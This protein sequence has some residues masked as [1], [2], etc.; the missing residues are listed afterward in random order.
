[1]V[2]FC[3]E[4]DLKPVLFLLCIPIFSLSLDVLS[5]RKNAWIDQAY[6]QTNLEKKFG[7]F[8]FWFKIPESSKTRNSLA[9]PWKYPVGEVEQCSKQ[10]LHFV[11][12]WFALSWPFYRIYCSHFPG[13]ER[14]GEKRKKGKGRHKLQPERDKRRKE[15]KER[16]KTHLEYLNAKKE[17]SVKLS[18]AFKCVHF[19]L[20]V[21]FF[22]S[23]SF[24]TKNCFWA[25]PLLENNRA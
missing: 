12:A 8:D 19:F 20:K 18:K 14:K 13:K 15:E 17:Y 7:R 25:F 23:F 16:S 11:R 10:L 5:I 4:T 2:F 6:K 1:M 24:Q 21:F 3:H 22:F 9:F